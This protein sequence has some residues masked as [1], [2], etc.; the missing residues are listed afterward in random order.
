[1]FLFLN[2]AR[3]QGETGCHF[4]I[5]RINTIPFYILYFRHLNHCGQDQ[6]NRHVERHDQIQFG[7][8]NNMLVRNDKT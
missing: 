6:S 4:S 1:M 2:T 8:D 5:I 3:K 7:S